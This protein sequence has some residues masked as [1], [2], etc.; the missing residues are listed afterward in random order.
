M[1]RPHNRKEGEERVTR[2][3][4]SQQQVEKKHDDQ[5][6]QRASGASGTQRDRDRSAQRAPAVMRT[7]NAFFADE[8]KLH[9]AGAKE[10]QQSLAGE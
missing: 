3:Q 2:Q 10:G 8:R 6:G 4:P 9:V 1:V 7:F 5:Q